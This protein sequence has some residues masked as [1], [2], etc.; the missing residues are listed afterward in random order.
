MTNAST[1][2]KRTSISHPLQIAELASKTRHGR[3]GITFCPGKKQAN[4]A[5]GS[6]DRDL[7]LD[8][9][10]IAHWGAAAVITLVEP[11]ELI[12][13]GVADLGAQVAR[14]QMAWFHLPI[15]D[16]NVPD[17]RFE[18]AW[19]KHGRSLRQLLARGFDIVVHCK[20]G[21]GRAGMIAA[22]LLVELGEASEAAI[23]AVRHVRPGAI[24]T[25]EQERYVAAFSS[26]VA[27]AQA[28]IQ[29]DR[30]ARA[31]GTLFGL[32]A[33]DAVG[34]TLEFTRRDSYEPLTDMVGGGP[35]RLKPGQWTDDTAMA[36]A[37]A[38]SLIAKRGLAEDDLMQRFG[39]WRDEGAYSCT[40]ICFDIGVTT[41]DAISRWRKTGDPL[42]GS[43]N[44][45]SAGNGSVMRLAPVAVAYAS[46]RAALRE[47]AARQS[48][49]T[50]SAP[51]AVDACILYAELLADII[52]GQSLDEA[53]AALKSHAHQ[54]DSTEIVAIARGSWKGKRRDQI[55]SSGYVVHSLE[56]AIWCTARSFSFED[57]VLLAA[58]LGDDADTTAAIT[59]QLAGALYGL[60]GIPARWLDKLAWQ[61]RIFAS[62]EQLLVVADS[63]RR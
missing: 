55:H 47:V 26:F 40:G 15:A 41:S 24:E 56:A 38:D 7:A 4:A 12:E 17:A 37:L 28:P 52:E 14:R 19:E 11:H 36:L 60:P 49:T 58:N 50:H 44:P 20:G 43:N 61:E 21:L 32:A 63:T 5:T 46:D 62:G 51:A 30:K 18:L 27:P 13:L 39:A 53:L 22:R 33:G 34:T 16:F 9:D 45:R 48:R 6:W 25:R 23:A 59:G 8:L 57:A 1:T 42:A 3:I 2:N 54:L 29:P 10:A 35:F 31:L